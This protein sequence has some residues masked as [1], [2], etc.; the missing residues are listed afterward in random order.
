[1]RGKN[2][3]WKKKKGKWIFEEQKIYSFHDGALLATIVA[4]L[5]AV[6]IVGLPV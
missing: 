4:S 5:L 6:V 1:M 3:E 2:K